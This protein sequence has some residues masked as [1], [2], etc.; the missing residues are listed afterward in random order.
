MLDKISLHNI[1]SVENIPIG[2]KLSRYPQNVIESLNETARLMSRYSCGTEIRFVADSNNVCVTLTP[3][4]SGGDISVFCGDYLVKYLTVEKDKQVTIMLTR[5]TTLSGLD[6]SFFENNRFAKNVWRLYFHN[7]LMVLNS[8]DSMGGDI[9]PPKPEEL[10]AKTMLAYG[11]SITHGAGA[12][13]HYCCYASTLAKLLGVDLLNKGLGG[14]CFLEKSVADFF[15]A[16][17]NWDFALLE[18]GVNMLDHFSVEE[19]DERCT[20]FIDKMAQTKKTLILVT[21]FPNR[22]KYSIEKDAYKKT[23]AFDKIIERNAKKHNNCILIDGKKVLTKTEF[24][25]ADG[26]HPNTEGHLFMGL[27]LYNELKEKA[28]VTKL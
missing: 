10:P 1:D 2:Y 28:D 12:V 13:D 9:R 20:Y 24:L 11:S 26:I 19:F 4:L 15:S 22:A 5:P 7:S 21:I 14:S 17:D 27:N 16:S 6:D 18:L 23:N 8:I 25:T 3:L